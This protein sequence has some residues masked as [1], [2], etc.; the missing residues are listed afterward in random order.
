MMMTRKPKMNLEN[1]VKMIGLTIHIFTYFLV[2]IASA[3]PTSYRSSEDI[4]LDLD[5][6]ARLGDKEKML[7]T[8]RK[9]AGALHAN[10]GVKEV[11]DMKRVYLKNTTVTCNDGSPAG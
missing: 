7:A 4:T 9:L 3:S 6:L 8:I 10:C 1:V 11:P 2:S 5:E